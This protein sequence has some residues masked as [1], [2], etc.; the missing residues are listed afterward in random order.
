M[1]TGPEHNLGKR[2]NIASWLTQK[3]LLSLQWFLRL[4]ET[5][6][7]TFLGSS[8]SLACYGMNELLVI[9]SLV[10]Y[11]MNDLLVIVS[12]A[13]YEMNELLVI[14]SLACY[15]MNELLWNEWIIMEWMN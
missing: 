12:F 10:C 2:E 11:G 6:E 7:A 8:V 4:L 3:A 5:K 15:G 1:V 14:V 9:V 13:C